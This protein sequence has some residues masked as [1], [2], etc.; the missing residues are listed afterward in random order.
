MSAVLSQGAP[1]FGRARGPPWQFPGYVFFIFCVIQFLVYPIVGA[2]LERLLYGTA[3]KSRKLRYAADGTSETVKVTELSKHYP[4]GWFSRTI[5]S[6]FT[7]NPAQTVRAVDNVSLSVLRGQIMV[8]LGA[9]GSGK[10]TTLDTL[11]GMQKP[12]SGQIEMD[13]TGGIGLCPQKNVLWNELT[14]AEHVTIFNKLKATNLDTK[15]QTQELV[16]ACDLEQKLNART[17]TLSG[18][19]KRKCQLA[20]MLTGGSSVRAVTDTPRHENR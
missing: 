7:K 9:N 5:G 18:G 12:T 1:S 11:A 19:Q 6:K 17:E 10:S 16:A 13:A 2:L 15:T 20:M 3:S 14:V 8:L 4:P